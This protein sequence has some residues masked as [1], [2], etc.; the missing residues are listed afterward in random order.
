VNSVLLMLPP[1]KLLLSGW[2]K[3]SSFIFFPIPAVVVGRLS[4]SVNSGTG[5]GRE[6]VLSWPESCNLFM[7]PMSRGWMSW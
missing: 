5:A 7:L 2:S 4:A 3:E 1:P 6:P